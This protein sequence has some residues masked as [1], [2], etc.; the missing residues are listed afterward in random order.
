MTN[1]ERACEIV[2]KAENVGLTAQVLIERALDEAEK[3]TR[4][5]AGQVIMAA[6]EKGQKEMRERAAEDCRS[7]YEEAYQKRIRALP[8]EGE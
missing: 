4:E 7:E 5:E 6:Y 1:K 3:R 8:I 2:L